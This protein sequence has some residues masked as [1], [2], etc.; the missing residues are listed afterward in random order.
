MKGITYW[1]KKLKSEIYILYYASRDPRVSWLTKLF[2]ALL[3]AYILSPVD[4]IPDF[5]PVLG[6]LDDLII[7]PVG[8]TIALRMIPEPVVTEAK[9]KAGHLV[10]KAKSW[11]G[12]AIVIAI[13]FLVL[14]LAY[15]FLLT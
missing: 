8:I 15:K 12:A 2:I 7:V 14:A 4:L 13:W 5:I 1:A 6:Y 10:R 3:V 9:A 11:A